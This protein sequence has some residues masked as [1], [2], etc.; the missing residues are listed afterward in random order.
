M[1]KWRI[2]RLPPQM[3]DVTERSFD[4]FLITLDREKRMISKMMV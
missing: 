3:I 1:D 2:S 4:I